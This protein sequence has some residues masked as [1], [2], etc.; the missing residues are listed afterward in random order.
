MV[1]DRLAVVGRLPAG[2]SIKPVRYP[3]GPAWGRGGRRPLCVYARGNQTND[4]PWIEIRMTQGRRAICLAIPKP[5]DELLLF[6]VSFLLIIFQIG[7]FYTTHA[8]T[9]G[10]NPVVRIVTGAGSHTRGDTEF[11]T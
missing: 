8:H 11:G 6:M 7:L 3:G 1:G 5:D 9:P 2:A 10:R 4:L